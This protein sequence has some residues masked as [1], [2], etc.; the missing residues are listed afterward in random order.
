MFLGDCKG[1][2]M[3]PLQPCRALAVKQKLREI[4]AGWRGFLLT[5]GKEGRWA[6][7]ALSRDRNFISNVCLP[8]CL[9]QVRQWPQRC[10]QVSAKGCECSDSTEGVMEKGK[11][12]GVS[13]GDSLQPLAAVTKLQRGCSWIQLL[14]PPLTSI[15]SLRGV[16]PPSL[17]LS[18]RLLSVFTFSPLLHPDFLISSHF[19][20]PHC[21]VPSAIQFHLSGSPWSGDMWIRAGESTTSSCKWTLRP[22]WSGMN[23][24]PHGSRAYPIWWCNK[25]IGVNY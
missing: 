11:Q 10:F 4:K 25:E 5:S 22:P 16:G 6:Y 18:P 9:L 8:Y 19:L 17:F 7:M 13:G 14:I 20:F 12:Y 21:C 15:P 1:S 3:P 2:V 23:T 24:P